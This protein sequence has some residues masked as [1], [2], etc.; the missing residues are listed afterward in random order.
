MPTYDAASTTTPVRK[1]VVGKKYFAYT[2]DGS[3]GY[4]GTLETFLGYGPDK[5]HLIVTTP[6]PKLTNIPKDYYFIFIYDEME[7]PE[8]VYSGEKTMRVQKWSEYIITSNGL[9]DDHLHRKYRVTFKE[10]IEKPD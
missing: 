3:G 9:I 2:S 6:I 1:L 5:N 7:W 10:A 4:W 8:G